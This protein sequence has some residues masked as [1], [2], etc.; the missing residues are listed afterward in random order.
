MRK[1]NPKPLSRKLRAEAEALAAMPENE[2]DTSEMPEIVDWSGAVRGAFYRPIKKP[3]SLRIDADVID[4]F[5]RQGEGYQS[6]MN[7]ALRE[8][9]E[10][11]R[12]RA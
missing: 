5:R 11:R 7:A 8:Y 4:W 10:R 1:G 2:V 9:V 3:L 12:K 6:R